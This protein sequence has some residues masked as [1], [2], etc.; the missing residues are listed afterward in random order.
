MNAS[1]SSLIRRSA[2]RAF[3]AAFPPMRMLLPIVLMA[4]VHPAF[5]DSEQF[6]KPSGDRA[7]RTSDAIAVTASTVSMLSRTGSTFMRSIIR[8]G[9]LSDGGE[10]SP[11]LSGQRVALTVR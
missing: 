9:T 11:K 5:G 1:A 3:A 8:L 10:F 4:G 6:A 7:Y 2:D